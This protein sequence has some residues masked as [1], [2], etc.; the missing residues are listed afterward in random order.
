MVYSDVN[1]N[2]WSTLYLHF[3][4]LY[5][6][7]KPGWWQDYHRLFNNMLLPSQHTGLQ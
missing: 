1:I 5:K 4:K 3:I 2:Q 6:A 7:E